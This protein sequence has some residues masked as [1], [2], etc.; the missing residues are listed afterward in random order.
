MK[1]EQ[2]QHRDLG[3]ERLGA[4]DADLGA[5][6][7][8]DAAVGLAGDR[9]ADGVD[10]RQSRMPSTLGFSQGAERVGRLARLAQDEDERPIVER[11]IA[12][13]ELAGVLD[14]DRADARAARS[15]IRPR[16]RRASSCRR[17]QARSGGRAGAA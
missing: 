10:D 4:G 15:G 1:G 2:E 3:R 16:A 5:G 7:E 11:C 17:R 8:V 12:V 13:A 9:A 14:L 6:V